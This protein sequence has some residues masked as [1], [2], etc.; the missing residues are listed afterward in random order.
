MAYEF[1]VTVDCADPHAM[2][3]WWAQA[4]LTGRAASP[5]CGPMR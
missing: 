3:D 1:Q 4:E 2:A 5:A